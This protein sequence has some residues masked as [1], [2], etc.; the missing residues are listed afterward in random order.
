MSTEDVHSRSEEI[1]EEVDRAENRPQE[2]KKQCLSAGDLYEVI[3]KHPDWRVVEATDNS[4]SCHP[5]AQ[6]FCQD[7]LRFEYDGASRHMKHEG[8]CEDIIARYGEEPMD[9]VAYE[10]PVLIQEM[11]GE[12]WGED[13]THLV[14]KCTLDGSAKWIKLV[15]VSR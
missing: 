13:D 6:A 5:L 15:P 4:D 3:L 8:M 9:E 12:S 2:S 1:I 10:N 14:K 11:F 7:N